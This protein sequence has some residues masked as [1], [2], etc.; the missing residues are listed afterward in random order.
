MIDHIENY[1]EHNSALFSSTFLSLIELNSDCSLSTAT[2]D[3]YSDT[4]SAVTADT[5]D[6][7]HALIGQSL[8]INPR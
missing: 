3:N 2:E 8:I 1:S 5:S 7:I 4:V 6:S